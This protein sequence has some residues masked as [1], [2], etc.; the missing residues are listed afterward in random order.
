MMRVIL[1]LVMIVTIVVGTAN[2]APAPAA[3]SSARPTPSPSPERVLSLIRQVF[4]SHRPPPP[5]V[6]YTMEREQLTDQG[7]P[8][9]V[10]SYKYHIWCR[11]SDR[12][13]LARKVFRD[14]ARGDLEFQ[15]PA[16]NE[17]R[18]PGP[19]TADIFEPAPLHPHPISFVPTPEANQTPLP[20]IGRVKTIGEYD[21]RVDSVTVEGEDLH[22]RLTPYRDPDRNRIREIF[23]N[24]KTY[25]LRK[26]VATD[27]LFVEH[28]KVYA[29][30]FTVRMGMLAGV[31]VVT[32]IHGKVGD[33]YS[34]DGEDVDFRFR[35]IAFPTSLPS[36][37]FDA[38]SYASHRNDAPS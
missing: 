1:K 13:A 36:W 14:Y 34:G 26:L 10:E 8:D 27:K 28:D 9:Y 38:H 11:S 16:F 21:Y 15:R 2:L 6:T 5:Y 25:E 17:A 33:N 24:K 18:D 32:D 3:T 7:F 35:D 29:V 30:T 22:L 12:A 4:R 23:A 20:I 19:P 37:Y 31:P